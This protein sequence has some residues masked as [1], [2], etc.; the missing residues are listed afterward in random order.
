MRSRALVAAAGLLSVLA[1]ATVVPAAAAAADPLTAVPT[2]R[3]LSVQGHGWGHG[4]G[5]SQNGAYGAAAKYGMTS[6]QIL[7]FYYPGTRPTTIAD[8]TVRVQLRS[9]EA[10]GGSSGLD[11]ENPGQLAVQDEA[12][13][14]SYLVS[15]ATSSRW[16]V[17]PTTA[18]LRVQYLKATRWTTWGTFAGPLRLD[19]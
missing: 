7:G 14:T 18:G 9:Q 13:K 5:M 10:A 17:Q 6:A 8:R 1:G 19:A 11:V 4:R 2:T 3:L 16:R 12:S 15:S